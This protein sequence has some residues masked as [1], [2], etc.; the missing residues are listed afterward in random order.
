MPDEASK[1]C[2]ELIVVPGFHFDLG[3]CDDPAECPPYSDSII[4]AVV[5]AIAGDFPGY[6]FNVEY[7]LFTQHF[8]KRFPNHVPLVRRLIEEGR[9]EVCASAP[10]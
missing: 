3:W 2:W 1:P 8:F 7:A 5:D 6:R 4:T 9:L 10:T